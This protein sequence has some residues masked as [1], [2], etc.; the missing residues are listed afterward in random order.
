MINNPN[1]TTPLASGV[2]NNEIPQMKVELFVSCKNLMNK[3]L[4]SKSDPCCFFYLNGKEIGRTEIIKDSLNPTFNKS[5]LIDYKFEEIQSLTF[6]LFDIDNLSDTPLD[7]DFLGELNIKLSEIVSNKTITKNLMN[8]RRT[9]LSTTTNQQSSVITIRCEERTGKQDVIVL[10]LKG[11]NLPK[12]DFFGKSDPYYII[13]KQVNNNQ[14]VE[15]SKSD[16]VMNDLNPNWKIE[17]IN[18]QRLC[19]GNDQLPLR[20]TIYDWDKNSAH[21]Y[22]GSC[23]LTLS[24]LRELHQSRQSIELVDEKNTKKNTKSRGRLSVHSYAVEETYSF[25]DYLSGGLDI[26]LMVSV[27]F[28]GSNGNPNDV[29]SLH[30]LGKFNEYQMAISSVGNVL[31]Y[32]DSDGLFP[33][34]GFGAKLN[35]TG[36]VSHCFALDGNPEYPYCSGVEGILAS[37]KQAISNVQLYGPT[38][39]QPTIGTA[40]SL[41]KSSAMEQS[42]QNQKYYILLIITDG[43][44]SDLSETIT[45]IVNASHYP[46]S[47]VIVGVGSADFSSMDRLDSDNQRLRSGNQVALRDIVQFVPFRKYASNYQLLANETL[48]E[49]PHQIVEYFKMKKIKPNPKRM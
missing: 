4:L 35:T 44:I 31:S 17:T 38:N 12:M 37:Y 10:G 45:E 18:I 28:T 29:N 3:D 48:A 13:E 27:D 21:D 22:I 24:K 26:S 32:Y 19:N 42:Q 25:I 2:N 14:W 47:I 41:C 7:D 9:I 5:L 34:F 30:Y 8:H 49:I 33:A 6:K 39:F 36:Q 15:V 43:E 20:I 46:L 11:E 40:V 16:V 23:Y 1:V